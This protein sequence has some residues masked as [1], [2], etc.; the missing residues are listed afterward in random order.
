MTAEAVMTVAACTLVGLVVG[1]F[2]NVVV[3]RVPAEESVVRPG[4]RCPRCGTPIAPRD[5]IPVLSWLLLHGR[6]RCCGTP[7]SARYPIVELA[8][9]AAFGVV[10]AWATGLWTPARLG[11]DPAAMAADSLTPPA[12]HG[13]LWPLPAFLY[14]AAA[15]IALAAIDLDTHRLPFWIVVPSWWVSGVLLGGAALLLGHPAAIGRT[16]AGG[17]AL[18]GLYRL[19]HAVY[20]PGMG[21]GDV[22]LAGLLGMYLSW[23]DWGTLAAGAFLGFLVGGAGGLALVVARRSGLKTEIPFGPYMLVGAWIGIFWGQQLVSA[24]LRTTGV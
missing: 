2:L 23:L 3:A 10:T 9:A 21:Y 1:S 6:A 20:P 8:T 7:I 17:L 13:A 18:W 15:G 22:R 12:W 4:S 11:E 24:Y 19:L 16:L 5:N 14:L